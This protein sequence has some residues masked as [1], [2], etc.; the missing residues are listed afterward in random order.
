MHSTA[1]SA[2]RDR[3]ALNVQELPRTLLS[4][5]RLL[6]ASIISV[7][8]LALIGG[9]LSY[10]I[11]ASAGGH[12]HSVTSY[13]AYDLL[14]PAPTSYGTLQVSRADMVPADDVVKVDVTLTVS[15][16]QALQTDAPRIEDLRLITT[17]GTDVNLRP[18]GWNG[19]AVLTANSK[20][21]IQLEYTAPLN[22]GLLWLEYTDPAGQ[23][24]LRMILG[25]AP[26][27]PQS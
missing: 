22:A 6:V 8:W 24:P 9:I 25:D 18:V 13:A 27:G 5:Q 11:L 20:N 26:G 19:P 2:T 21:T 1:A 16:A 3:I 4:G 12:T 15:N 14:Q 10:Y 23:W 7:T 17:D